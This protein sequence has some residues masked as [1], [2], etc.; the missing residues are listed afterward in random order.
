[1]ARIVIAIGETPGGD[2]VPIYTGK[3]AQAAFTAVSEAGQS[4]RIVAGA[5]YRDPTPS[6]RIS[7]A[8]SSAEQDAAARLAKVQAAQQQQRA[9]LTARVQ[10]VAK[11][12]VGVIA[13][14][15]R[16]A[17]ADQP[18]AP[19]EVATPEPTVTTVATEGDAEDHFGAR[20]RRTAKG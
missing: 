9:V 14:R 20:R 15:I 19:A 3:D 2:L 13:E 17:G 4:G 16:E 18:E 10:S 1:M 6:R 8:R 5:I 12:V 11:D 7:F